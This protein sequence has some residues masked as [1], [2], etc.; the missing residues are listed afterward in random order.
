MHGLVALTKTG[1]G[2]VERVSKNYYLAVIDDNH[3]NH[4]ELAAIDINTAQQAAVDF[5]ACNGIALQVFSIPD[6]VQ[7]AHAADIQDFLNDQAGKRIVAEM[8]LRRAV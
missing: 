1:R 8:P 4:Y 5:C 2:R 3:R 6:E 7:L